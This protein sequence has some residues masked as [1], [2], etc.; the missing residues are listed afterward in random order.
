MA[1]DFRVD[2]FSGF[3]FVTRGM[4]G[5]GAGWKTGTLFRSGREASLAA[6]GPLHHAHHAVMLS[7][8]AAAGRKIRVGIRP[9]N[10]RNQRPTEDHH[11]RKCDRSAHS[12]RTN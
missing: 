7:V 1:D 9:K 4:D 12:Q 8:P 10:G 2:L 3:R 5:A 11:Q 6:A